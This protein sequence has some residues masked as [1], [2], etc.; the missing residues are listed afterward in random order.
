[1]RSAAILFTLTAFLSIT[2]AVAGNGYDARYAYPAFGPL[3]A[4]AALGAWGVAIG[5]R[6]QIR[7]RRQRAD[8]MRKPSA[9]RL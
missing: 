3:A 6:R 9:E 7:R 8:A 1:V 2:L 4:G 5:L